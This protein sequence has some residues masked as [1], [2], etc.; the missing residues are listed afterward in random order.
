MTVLGKLEEYVLQLENAVN[1]LRKENQQLQEALQDKSKGSL[2]DEQLD[3][4]E[5]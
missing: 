4:F 1:Q 3:G 2:P 5:E